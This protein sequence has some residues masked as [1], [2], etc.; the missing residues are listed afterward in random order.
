M[1]VKMFL[2]LM[3]LCWSY[4]SSFIVAL[5][6][7]SGTP[8]LLHY[9]AYTCCLLEWSN[10]PVGSLDCLSTLCAPL[11][12]SDLWIF[13]SALAT[14]IYYICFFARYS[15]DTRYVFKIICYKFICIQGHNYDKLVLRFGEKCLQHLVFVDVFW[16]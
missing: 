13:S 8:W 14:S 1:L 3:P 6:F 15:P 16:R 9:L 2:S 10:L 7:L 4:Y 5:S 11:E 12:C